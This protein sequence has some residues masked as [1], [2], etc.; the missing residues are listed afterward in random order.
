MEPDEISAVSDSLLTLRAMTGN[1]CRQ[2]VKDKAE[3]L[4]D[5]MRLIFVEQAIVEVMSTYYDFGEVTAV[6]RLHGGL[7]NQSYVVATNDGRRRHRLF[8]KRYRREA[9]VKEILLEHKYN[10]YLCA[11]GFPEVAKCIKTK[12]GR[13]FIE[14]PVKNLDPPG[15]PSKFALYTYLD[16]EDRYGWLTPYCTLP[17]IAHASA[18]LAKIHERGFGFDA[19]EYAREEPKIIGL[20]DEFPKYFA[21]FEKKA[22]NAEIGCKSFDYFL[23]HQPAYLEALDRCHPLKDDCRDMLEVMIHGDYHPGNQ[24]YSDEGIV[25]VF[26]FDWV[27]Q[28]LRLLDVALMITYFCTSWKAHENGMLFLDE[29]EALL[30]AYQNYLQGSQRI[31]PMTREE[32]GALPEMILMANMYVIWWDLREIFEVEES[33]SCEEDCLAYLDHNTRINDYALTHLDDLRAVAEKFV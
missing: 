30:E 9:S 6:N 10:A 21:E 16:G 25:G 18:M 19:G 4:A 26:D 17:E 11:D 13:S 24:K 22:R 29:I 27:K 14:H 12:D 33:E 15:A 31:Y 5:Q 2:E 32:L 7:I 20:L 1:G 23:E 8:I 3:A 28:D